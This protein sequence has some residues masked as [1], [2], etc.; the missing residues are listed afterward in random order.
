MWSEPR[1]SEH[2]EIDLFS[3]LEHQSFVIQIDF[4]YKGHW[5]R[6]YGQNFGTKISF[7]QLH[8][9]KKRDRTHLGSPPPSSIWQNTTNKNGGY[10]HF[11]GALKNQAKE[12]PTYF[13]WQSFMSTR[14]PFNWEFYFWTIHCSGWDTSLG[15][16]CFSSLGTFCSP[17]F[18]SQDI[19][20][21]PSNCPNR[22]ITVLS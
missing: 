14:C 21:T 1:K 11:C 20:D 15:S 12:S 18:S 4:C 19:R 13:L 16:S 17:S 6:I 3:L 9:R 5:S 7:L 10:V 2:H 22:K 8:E